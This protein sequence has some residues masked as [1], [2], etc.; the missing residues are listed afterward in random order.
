MITVYMC[1]YCVYLY[2]CIYMHKSQN[3]YHKSLGNIYYCTWILR[4]IQI[5]IAEKKGKSVKGNY[6]RRDKYFWPDTEV[7]QRQWQ[8]RNSND[9][10]M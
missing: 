6:R 2:V 7:Y 4:G 5:K 3:N 8:T 9:M 1:I 10:V